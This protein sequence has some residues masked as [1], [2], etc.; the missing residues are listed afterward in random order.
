MVP[1]ALITGPTAG[2]GAEFAEQLAAAGY[3]LVLVS[4]DETRLQQTADR[5]R[6]RHR[7]EVEVLAA[8]LADLDATRRVAERLSC[9]ERPIELLV[10]NAGFGV[11][12]QTL[13]LDVDEQLRLLDVLCRAVLVLSHAAGT[14]MRARGSGA[15]LNVSSVAAY[16]P[17]SAY[18]AAKAWV[19]T[20]TEGLAGDLAGTGVQV[21]AVH[22]GFTHTEFHQ[23]ADLNMS[24]L[25][26]WGW[27]SVER[28][29][30]EALTDLR[31]GRVLSVPSR[32]YRALVLALRFAPSGLRRRG[33]AA[34]VRSRVR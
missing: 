17:L 2:L 26:E 32:R 8:D 1:T 23:R 19:T 15:I 31:R 11:N 20:F 10:N 16:G 5:L 18:S 3:D 22:P 28:V 29:V 34:L 21:C 7:V 33:S 27:L 30:T 14:A 4:R 24:K 25:P 6:S 12:G 9:T 13:D